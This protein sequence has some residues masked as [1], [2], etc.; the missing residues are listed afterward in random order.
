MSFK[1]MEPQDETSGQ[2]DDLSDNDD[3]ASVDDL[4][5]MLHSLTILLSSDEASHTEEGE[6][7]IVQLSNLAEKDPEFYKYLQE[8]DHELLDFNPGSAPHV[9]V[10]DD[11]HEEAEEEGDA[12]EEDRLPVL[13]KQ[14][15]R[16]WQKALL[17]VRSAQSCLHYLKKNC[18]KK[19]SLRALRKLLIAFRSAAHMNEDGQ[20]LA[21]SIDSSSGTSLLFIFSCILTNY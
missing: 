11:E 8:N 15:L 7:H 12:M 17:E 18:I 14:A 2:E 5:G 1:E 10:S 21:W 16:K 20:A 6:A 3:F 4:D 9:S 19:R 13:T